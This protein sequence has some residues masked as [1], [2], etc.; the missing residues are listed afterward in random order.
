MK[1][2]IIPILAT[3]SLM[4]SSAMAA[5]HNHSIVNQSV[6]NSTNEQVWITIGSDAIQKLKF[7]HQ[8][9]INLKALPVSFSS[10]ADTIIASL[11]ASQVNS[12]S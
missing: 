1:K 9:M 4:I 7:N 10:N 8:S 12:L 5:E 11:P 3:S 2:I 6:V